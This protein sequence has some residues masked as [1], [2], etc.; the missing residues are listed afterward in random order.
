M[1]E[2]TKNKLAVGSKNHNKGAYSLLELLVTL[3]ITS[4]IMIA[5]ITLFTNVLRLSAISYGRAEAREELVNFLEEFEKDLRNASQVG[6]CEGFIVAGESDSS[7]LCEFV[8]DAEY[9]WASCPKPAVGSS[10]LPSICSSNNFDCRPGGLTICKY[11]GD[12]LISNFNYFYNIEQFG[13]SGFST[14][15]DSSNQTL[16]VVGVVSHPN[17]TFEINNIVRQS[18]VSTKN[19]ERNVRAP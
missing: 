7:F 1:K 12:E 5:L 17:Q 18:V 13:V 11:R 3:V 2:N 15:T 6:T 19:F 4:I 10:G 14:N 16:S 8:T 9:R